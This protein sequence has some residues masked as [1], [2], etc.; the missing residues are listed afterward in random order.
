MTFKIKRLPPPGVEHR[1]ILK[2]KVQMR[3]GTFT[4]EIF[5]C[6]NPLGTLDLIEQHVGGWLGPQIQTL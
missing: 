2:Q 6:Q 1:W 4:E 5:I 3:V